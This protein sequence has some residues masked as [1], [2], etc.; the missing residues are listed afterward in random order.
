VAKQIVVLD[1]ISPVQFRYVLWA[2]VI[3]AR[4]SYYADPTLTSAYKG[5]SAPE[6]A[7]LRA[8]QVLEQTGIISKPSGTNVADLQADLQALFTTFQNDV[9]NN[10]WPGRRYGST[11]DGTTWTIV[12]IT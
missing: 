12:N 7:A 6:L 5:A 4:Q 2:T 9:N 8:G 11:W 3:A 10:Q 1:Q